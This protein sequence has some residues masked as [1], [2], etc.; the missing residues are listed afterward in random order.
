[1]LLPTTTTWCRKAKTISAACTHHVVRA[2][3]IN[4]FNCS[5]ADDDDDGLP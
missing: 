5:C 3:A 2:F 1:M 4:T